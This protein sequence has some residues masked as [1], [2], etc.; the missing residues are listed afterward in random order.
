MYPR[1]FSIDSRKASELRA[2]A[3][4]RSPAM[5]DFA[6][7]LIAT[8]SLPGDE[9]RIAA[10]VQ[11]ELARLDYDDVWVDRAG[12]VIG[13]LRGANGGKTTQFNSHLDHVDV[14]DLAL[15]P[16]PPLEGIVRDDILFG[17]GACDVKGAL[18]VQ[19]YAAAVL[20]DLGVRPSGDLYFA[21]VVLEE[22]GGFGSHFLARE[23]P[24]DFAVLGEAT[25]NQLKRGHRGRAFVKVSFAGISAHA[26]APD[27]A[28]NPLFA[29]GNFLNLLTRVFMARSETFGPSSAAPT[30]IETDQT[31]GNVTPGRVS[32][33]LDW[34]NIPEEAIEE[35]LAKINRIAQEAALER[36][37]I[38]A[39]VEV[40]GRPVK[41][42][43]GLEAVMPST[44][45][46]E[47]PLDDPLLS[48]ARR[49]L[50]SVLSRPIEVGTWTFATDGGH[51]AYHGITTFG[52]AP[53]SERHAHTVWDQVN[54]SEMTEALAGYAALALTLGDLR[55]QPFE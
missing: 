20:A 27:R 7:R 53:G 14:G 31:S 42:C 13:A 22:V 49:V 5:V 43:T 46:F 19:V 50:E 44:R 1:D 47:T 45:A 41:T 33:Y 25:G 51:L 21:G 38:S 37:G 35:V 9:A 6:R 18:A 26:S 28:R 29:V 48:A 55:D 4:L 34:R 3:I 54:L 16:L 39:R 17:R 52:F 11:S 40:V 8:P 23:M 15:W 2:A 32:I 10:V 12:N 24:T 36:E 30:L